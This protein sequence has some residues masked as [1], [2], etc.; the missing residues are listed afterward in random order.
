MCNTIKTNENIR[1]ANKNESIF[2]NVG[3]FLHTPWRDNYALN[4]TIIPT[5]KE[6]ATSDE[7]NFCKEL[8]AND[9]DK[10]YILERC[11]HNYISLAHFP[12][13]TNGHLLVLPKDHVRSLDLMMPAARAEM[14][15]IIS[16]ICCKYQN[17]QYDVSVGFNIG[18]SAGAGI[19]SHLH[20]H[21][22][23]YS[24]ED[25]DIVDSIEKEEKKNLN[26]DHIYKHTKKLLTAPINCSNE[27]VSDISLKCHFCLD[28]NSNNDEENFVIKRYKNH[29]I[30]L[31]RQPYTLGHLIISPLKHVRNLNNLTIES[32]SELIELAASSCAV[33]KKCMNVSDFN[34]GFNLS[35]KPVIGFSDHFSMQVMP[36]WNGDTSF[37]ETIGGLK[38]V[39]ARL[40]KMYADMKK[41]FD[42]IK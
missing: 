8:R 40:K 16:D 6:D 21:I 35:K 29:L 13:T 20:G 10:Y 26:L 28:I 17:A 2:V 27:M 7:C 41:E 23:P 24:T 15:E 25:T 39:S 34:V 1:T 19:P 14:V 38:V 9:D 3:G 32:R 31:S 22:V 42:Q 30:T 12:Y 36:R 33:L 5:K 18:K 4:N 11:N 37:I